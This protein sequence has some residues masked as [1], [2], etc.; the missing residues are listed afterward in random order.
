MQIGIKHGKGLWQMMLTHISSSKETVFLCLQRWSQIRYAYVFDFLHSRN[1]FPMS[2]E[3]DLMRMVRWMIINSAKGSA[4]T[5]KRRSWPRR[6]LPGSWASPQRWF[7]SGRTARQ[8]RR[9]I[10]SASLRRCSA[11][12]S[13]QNGVIWHSGVLIVPIR[14]RKRRPARYDSAFWSERQGSK[15]TMDAFSL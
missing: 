5:E 11:F 12:P 10:W 9:Q 6:S 14:D 13:I 2:E 15:P 8:S 3:S 7:Q 4:V 1:P